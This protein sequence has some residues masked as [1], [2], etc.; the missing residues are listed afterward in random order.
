MNTSMLNQVL[1]SC[2]FIVF[3]IE[4]RR[5]H[6]QENKYLCTMLYFHYEINTKYL[7]VYD[8]DFFNNEEIDNISLNCLHLIPETSTQGGEKSP[9]ETAIPP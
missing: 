7:K 4:S 8:Q 5:E 1:Y 6:D 2:S 3:R 9:S